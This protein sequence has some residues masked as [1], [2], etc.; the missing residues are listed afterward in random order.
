MQMATSFSESV[1]SKL[2]RSNQKTGVIWELG[3]GILLC[4][5]RVSF[6][7]KSKKSILLI[8]SEHI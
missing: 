7:R 8:H 6:S 4:I 2:V 5:S 3:V 1:D